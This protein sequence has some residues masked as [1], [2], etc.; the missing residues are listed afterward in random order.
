MM[1]PIKAKEAG[2]FTQ[3]AITPQL[4]GL[5]LPL[6]IGNILQQFYNTMDAAVVGRFLGSGAF[7]AVGVAGSLMNLFLFLISGCCAGVEVLLSQLCGAM[8]D[9]RFRRNL[10][11]AASFGMGLS[12]ALLL[13]AM[14]LLEPLLILLSTPEDIFSETV[15]YLRVIF[16]G[17][18]VA[19]AFHLGSSALRAL[20]NT[21]A[22]LMILALSVGGNTCL[23]ILFVAALGKGVQ[24]AALATVLSQLFAAVVCVI[25]FFKRFPSFM[26]HRGDMVLD[27]PLLFRT[28]KFAF[29][30]S[31]HMC[32]LYVGKLL[33]QGTVNSLGTEAVAAFTAATRIEGFANSF[34]DSG[35]AAMSIFIG[36]NT[37]AGKQDRAG[38]GFRAGSMLLLF[39]GA[40]VS[41]VMILAAEP[42]LTLVLP[43]DSAASMPAAS[44]YLRLVAC[45]YVFNYIGSGLAGFFRGHGQVHIPTLGSAFHI[46]LRV[47]LS[48][49]LAPVMG[50]P[51]VALACGLGWICVVIVWSVPAR[52]ILR[53]IR[54]NCE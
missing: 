28:A 39:F 13:A 8:D 15:Q 54:T 7:A 46:T 19:F 42:C 26:F 43:Q 25:Y 48:V 44:A 47:I 51:A 23:D 11:L 17:F 10:F 20:G 38:K 40:A 3:G 35:S 53:S 6:F 37:G 18:P 36:Q 22:A 27:R 16:L 24:W 21:R 14:L 2:R 4:M 31:L 34:G 49:L 30:S 32:S 5:A 1:D 45:F 50:L 33:V 12:L 9:V 29:A 41:L 52:K